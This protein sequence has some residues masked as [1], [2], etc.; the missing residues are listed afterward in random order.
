MQKKL[1][2]KSALLEQK[3]DNLNNAADIVVFGPLLDRLTNEKIPDNCFR[4]F[5]DGAAK[6]VYD[7]WQLVEDANVLII[8]DGDSLQEKMT[9]TV[10]LE[11]FDILL[12]RSKDFSDLAY[13]LK[14]PMNNVK[15]LTLFGFSGGELDHELSNIG[16]IFNYL[17]NKKLINSGA[18]QND[19]RVVVDK[20]RIFLAADVGIDNCA[21]LDFKSGFSLFGPKAQMITLTGAVEYAGNFSLTPFSSQG[22]S[23]K[24][25]GQFKITYHRPL[26]VILNSR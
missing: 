18:S 23:N 12:N 17:E 2:T 20:A 16:E 8:G 14:L 1:I 5:I 15:T 11:S 25:F 26:L 10:S 24:A 19:L 21:V 22:L 7:N 6:F 4:V 9:E 3:L 13:F